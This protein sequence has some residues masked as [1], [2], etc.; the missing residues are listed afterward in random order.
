M[1]TFIYIVGAVA[2]AAF[3]GLIIVTMHVMMPPAKVPFKELMRHE[4]NEMAY[5][6][7]LA[8]RYMIPKQQHWQGYTHPVLRST[9]HE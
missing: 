8:R 7:W 2:L 3:S 5:S 1:D 6:Q 9:H 4:G